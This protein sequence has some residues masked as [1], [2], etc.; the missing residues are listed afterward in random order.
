VSET[1]AAGGRAT[2]PAA[3]DIS[4]VGARVLRAS[5]YALT[6]ESPFPLEPDSLLRLRVIAGGEKADV[7]ARVA[8]CT[9]GTGGRRA[10]E[11][12]LE[13][14]AV[15]PGFRERLAPAPAPRGRDQ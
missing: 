4:V 15:P 5:R 7:E 1:R 3:P 12:G 14:T 13:L 6:I 8:A 10:F 2:G 11:V 9:A